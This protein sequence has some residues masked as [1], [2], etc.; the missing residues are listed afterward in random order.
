M[1]CGP[2]CGLSWFHVHLRVYS[3]A[4]G[5]KVLNISIRSSWTNVS[6][7]VC[8]SLLILCFDDLSFG[9]SGMLKSPTIIVLLS[10]APHFRPLFF[11]KYSRSPFL[12]SSWD[13]AM[14]ILIIRSGPCQEMFYCGTSLLTS[15]RSIQIVL[16]LCGLVLEGFCVSRNS[17][18]SSLLLQG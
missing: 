13:P 5:W 12:S 7:E 15:Y 2:R 4:F 11:F 3:S 16:F 10:I 17:G 1:I 8:V 18:L 9:V 14:H 6:F